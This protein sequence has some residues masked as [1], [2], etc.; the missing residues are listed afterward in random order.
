MTDDFHRISAA[1]LK[2]RGLIK[3]SGRRNSWSATITKTGQNY[4]D[5]VDGPEPPIPR[6]ENV[7]VTQQLVNDVVDAGGTLRVPSR[8]GR[9][10]AIDYEGRARLAERHRK[11]PPGKRLEISRISNEELELKLIDAPGVGEAEMIDVEVPEK[12]SRYHPAVRAFRSAKGSHYVSRDGLP[13][14]SRLLQAVVLEAQRRGWSAA[15][16]DED[17]TSGVQIAVDDQL[18]WISVS[19]GGV[20][21]RGDWEEEWECYRRLRRD[22]RYYGGSA[23]TTAYDAN[24]DGNLTLSLSCEKEWR[25]RGRQSNWSDRSSWQLDERLP[26]LF[27]EIE[28]RATEGTR[29]DEEERV[30]AEKDAARQ[31]RERDERQTQW[32]ALIETAKVKVVEAHRAAQLRRELDAWDLT[33][34][35][36]RYCEALEASQGNNEATSAWLTWARGYANRI[37]PTI[38][39]SELPPD[40]ELTHE[41][42]QEHLPSG[43]STYGPEHG[44][45]PQP[46]SYHQRW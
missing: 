17:K 3:I 27:V 23:P 35:I 37:D 44:W 33:H 12:V 5:E 9:P 43:W 25:Y 39:P 19:E 11:V 32:N 31:K 24:A 34:R 41:A 18:F 4:L 14:A 6:Q 30:Q 29:L 20:G 45:R 13:R 15:T 42:V 36:E 7:S 8:W 28:E 16:E 2:R 21:R 10:D 46:C 22:L 38:T 1:A 40:P 26:H